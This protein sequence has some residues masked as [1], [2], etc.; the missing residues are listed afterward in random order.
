MRS[1]KNG[2]TASPPHAKNAVNLDYC[3]RTD[4]GFSAK[5]LD[6]IWGQLGGV[7]YRSVGGLGGEF[8]STSVTIN[9]DLT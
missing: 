6:L 2:Q 8:G 1:K 4:Q 5:N 7:P 9:L 3:H